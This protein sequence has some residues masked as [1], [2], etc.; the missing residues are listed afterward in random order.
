VPKKVR[1]MSATEVKRLSFNISD[2]DPEKDRVGGPYSTLHA[3]GGVAGLLLQVNPSGAKSW[4]LRTKVGLKRKSIG[5]G[6]YPDVTLSDARKRA[7]EIKEK[8]AEGID[9][10]E[11]KKTVRREL[12][13][14]QLST[15]N[16]AWAMAKFIDEKSEEWKNPRQ[17]QQWVN[18]LTTYALPH[19]GSIPVSDIKLVHIKSVLEPIWKVKTETA[20]RVRARIENILGYCAVHGYRGEENPARWKGYLDKVYALP[21][22]IK[23][24][25]HH[26]AL[27]V[28]ELPAFIKELKIRQ[29][30]AARSLEFLILTASRTNEVIGDK[31][32]KKNGI[33]WKEIDLKKKV[34]A[35]PAERM[36]SGKAHKVPLCD[37][38]MEIL[39]NIKEGEPEELIFKGADG[40]IPSNNFLSS[41]LKRMGSDVTVHGFRS[42]FKDWC[43]EH[44]AYPD[45]VSELALAHVNS[46]A[47]RAAYARSEL[48]EKRRLLMN[49]WAD[50]CYHGE[51]IKGSKVT[52]IGGSK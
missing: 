20:T 40:G 4:I 18:S 39:N 44:T 25:K 26:T 34:W 12:I 51:V 10:V 3:V 28:K 21:E 50:Y 15:K 5:L 45:E 11:Q 46:D 19:I 7:R 37:S 29:G 8:I 43:S 35:I 31:R 33:T 22:K 23:K 48:L 38:A 6:G 13:A 42:T 47:T 9:P 30:A 14:K 2:P 52:A 17:K 16:F 27:S 41:L 36:K 1:E 24:K 49:D 32:I